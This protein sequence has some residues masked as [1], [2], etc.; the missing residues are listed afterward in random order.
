MPKIKRQFQI[1]KEVSE[2]STVLSR[3]GFSN[4]IVGGSVRDLIMGRVPKDWDIATSATPE[5]IQKV[6]PDSFY[7]NQFGTVGVKTESIGIVEVTPYRLESEYSDARHP[8]KIA[9]AKTI[10]EDLARRDFTINAL[11]H[12]IETGDL[13]D[14]FE[15]EADIE[16]KLIR[17][18]GNPD[19]RFNEDALRMFRALRFAIEL[20]F[21]IELE[22][23][24]AI[25]KNAELL[26]KVSKERIRD[27]LIK[28]II[29][30]HPALALD[31]AARLGIL[32]FISPEF[33]K[34]IGM[35]QN[36]AHAYTVWEHLLR[37]LDHAAKKDYPLH[38]RLAAF[39]HD[40]GKPHT[41][42]R[43]NDQ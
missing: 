26:A 1:Q 21:A 33:E 25:T 7:E 18:V 11:A 42:D 28:I 29:S 23:Q 13:I 5:E 6:F 9:W 15:G 36:Q 8:D 24:A 34:G 31:L 39:F 20:N 3:A 30:D 12:N 43:R 2:I 19:E 4:F 17:T 38:V 27:E 40:V 37:S 22:T 16:K 35:E 10:E 14:P 41:R 32:K